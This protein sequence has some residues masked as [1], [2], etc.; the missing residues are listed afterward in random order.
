MLA[1]RFCHRLWFSSAS[2]CWRRCPQ[3]DGALKASSVCSELQ[4]E[5][6][7]SGDKTQIEAG[8]AKESYNKKN[9]ETTR[10]SNCGL[11]GSCF[12]RTKKKPQ[13]YKVLLPS[14]YL[15]Y[16]SSR[17]RVFLSVIHVQAAH[18]GE[19]GPVTHVL[20]H[21]AIRSAFSEA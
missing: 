20:G 1:G 18:E 6:R 16:L 8:Y 5:I 19:E 12:S 4:N 9:L 3:S 21:K 15:T 14:T 11:N 10:N 2:R 13:M 17:A 7:L